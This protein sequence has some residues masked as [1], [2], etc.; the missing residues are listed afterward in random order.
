M[1]NGRGTKAAPGGMLLRAL[2]CLLLAASLAMLFLPWVS[3]RL[4]QDG[5]RV[6]LREAAELSRLRTGRGFRELVLEPLPE[7][8]QSLYA[9][10]LTRL[11]P[12]LDDRMSPVGAALSSADCARWLREQAA[13]VRRQG[14]ADAET[15]AW[16]GSLEK[17]GADLR[18]TA[19][20]QIVLL[21]L[22]A[23]TGIYALVS[24]AEGYSF[25]TLPYLFCAVLAFL[26][27]SLACLKGNEWYQGGS[28]PARV[29]RTA[30]DSFRSS[31]NPVSEPFRMSPWGILFL[32]LAVLGLLLAIGAPVQRKIPARSPEGRGPARTPA[33]TAQNSPAPQPWRCPFCG[34]LMGD[35]VYCVKCGSRKPE[36]RR[37]P[38]CGA[39]LEKGSLYC[40]SCGKALPP[41]I[42][43]PAPRPGTPRKD[44]AGL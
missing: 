26:S 25:G 3:L 33:A 30:V 13:A 9:G 23:V 1:D 24:A 16:C 4:E 17:T 11:D 44:E 40:T 35:G 7:R 18:L 43:R 15:A 2:A 31:G 34:T 36:P 12:L 29:L 32:V 38:A 8:D 28:A 41:E 37:C 22:L 10:L 19:A 5:G 39:L 6:C 42:G 14:A 20:F 27:G 21:V